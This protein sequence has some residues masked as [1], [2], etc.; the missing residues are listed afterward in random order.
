MEYLDTIRIGGKTIE[1][2]KKYFSG[3]MEIVEVS[4]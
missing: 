3:K 2:Y 4:L 1:R